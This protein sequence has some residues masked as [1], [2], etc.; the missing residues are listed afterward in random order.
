MTEF[1]KVIKYLAIALAAFLAVSIIG[2]ALSL[3]GVLGGFFGDNALTEDIKG[4]TVSSDI[5]SIEVKINAADFVIKQGD[6]FFVES[7]LKYLKVEDNGG[8][9]TI[10]ETKKLR[11]VTYTD[12]VL[13]VYI[14]AN[15]VFENANITTGAGRFTA[16]CL[17]ANTIKFDLG[18]GE[19]TVDTLI[20][21][22]NIDIN[23][24]AGKISI[25]GGTLHSLDLDMGIGQL[26]LTCALTGEN[27]F[28]LGVGESNIT[29]IG[30]KNDY[31]L[32]IE[33][34]I[35][36]ITVNGTAVSNIKE[37]KKGKNSINISGGIGGINLNFKEAGAE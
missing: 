18:A 4:Y 22:S 16:D 9:L 36:S 12:A 3:L 20:A 32:D 37:Q 26:N 31:K 7:N 25:L 21:T 19:V 14:P 15:T 33:K 17:S 28:D 29:V 2:G 13:T 10:K 23:G 30:K 11:G 35:G 5:S 6:S 1:Q 24:G 8:V 27:D 34:G